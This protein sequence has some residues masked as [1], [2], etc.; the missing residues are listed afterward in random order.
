MAFHLPKLPYSFDAL[1]PYIDA[2]TME[3]HYTK[4]HQAYVTNLNHAV[5]KAPELKHCGV[6]DIV[7]LVG[8]DKVPESVATT[9]RN[10]GGGA[11]E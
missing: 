6:D 3:I 1:E 7:K 9:V 5:E 8:T 2:L 11:P 10:N 4:H